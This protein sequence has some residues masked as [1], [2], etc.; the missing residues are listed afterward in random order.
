MP[1][2]PIIWGPFTG[3]ASS[4]CVEVTPNGDGFDFTSTL[5]ADKGRVTYTA[6]EVAAFLTDV[7]AGKWDAVQAR[8]ESLALAD[9]TV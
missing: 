2:I 4:H 8:A 5:G 3:C 6:A 9:A 7:K 1:F